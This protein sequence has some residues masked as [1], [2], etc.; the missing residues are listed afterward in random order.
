MFKKAIV[1]TPGKSMING[2]TT[3]ELDLPNYEIPHQNIQDE[4][5]L[6]HIHLLRLH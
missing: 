2:L 3:A 5:Q 6:L 4:T 1:R